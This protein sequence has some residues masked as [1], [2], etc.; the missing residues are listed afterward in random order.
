MSPAFEYLLKVSVSLA[1]VSLLYRFVLSRFTFYNWNR[2]YLL[3][4][5]KACLL[6]PLIDIN[7]SLPETGRL[8]AVREV[9]TLQEFYNAPAVTNHSQV[10]AEA[11]FDFEMWLWIALAAGAA[12]MLVRLVLQWYSL[13]RIRRNASLVSEDDVKIYHVEKDIVPFS[14]GDAIFYNPASHSESDLNDIILHEYIHVRERHTLDVLWGEILCIFNWYNPF[15]WLI[16]WSIRQNL[17]YI[18]DRAVLANDVDR[19][20]YQY[21]LLKVAGFSEFQIGNPFSVSSLKRRIMMMNKRKTPRV[22]LISFLLILPVALTLLMIF[23]KR[24]VDRDVFNK[25]A[26]DLT[27]HQEEL[28][29]QDERDL[30]IS[31]LILDARTGEPIHN[32]PL[33]IAYREKPLKTIRTDSKGFYFLRVPARKD[34][35]SPG[36]GRYFDGYP[37]SYTVENV[38]DTHKGFIFGESRSLDIDGIGQFKI[39]YTPAIDEYNAPTSFFGVPKKDVVYDEDKASDQNVIYDQL[40]TASKTFRKEQAL[41]VSFRDQYP[42]PANIITKHGNGYFDRKR[43]MLGYEG[44]IQ[45]YLDGKKADYTDVNKA[46]AGSPY[47]LKQTQEYRV[48]ENRNRYSK[49]FYLTFDLHKPAPPHELL[50]GNVEIINPRTFNP[51]K[52]KEKAYLLDGFRQVFGVGSN[53]L[54]EKEEIIKVLRFKGS[55]A[56]YYDRTRDEIWWVET[57][58]AAEVFERPDF[59]G[60]G[61]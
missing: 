20:N 14:F 13:V 6:V 40:L 26:A 24:D 58:P 1:I 4:A 18:A 55:L 16:R 17:E 59:A 27:Q 60:V 45:F 51:E 25:L 11:G 19:R 53:M 50:A 39:I 54:P 52:L 22:L 31:G 49:I 28:L 33:Q 35:K 21:L 32:F 48:F 3:F 23:R 46:F 37:E 38:S 12:V 47:M 5:S 34:E 41:I 30:V 8:A 29:N 10:A 9:P 2:W 44:E 43:E 57:R 42:R 56:R 15:A 61:K 36:T 7:P